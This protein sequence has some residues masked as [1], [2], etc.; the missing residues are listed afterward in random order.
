MP[1]VRQ[2]DSIGR[3]GDPDAWHLAASRLLLAGRQCVGPAWS[4]GQASP[5]VDA[6]GATPLAPPSVSSSRPVRVYSGRSV[7][8]TSVPSAVPSAVSS[9]VSR[10]VAR[11][12]RMRVRS[13]AH[14]SGDDV[15]SAAIEQGR[16]E[17][18]GVAPT[19]LDAGIALAR[20]WRR[21][22]ARRH[23]QSHANAGPCSPAD[24]KKW[25]MGLLERQPDAGLAHMT[26]CLSVRAASCYKGSRGFDVRRDLASSH[27]PRDRG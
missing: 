25:R 24:A 26:S 20:S 4:R 19:I 15:Q 3:A 1:A 8:T 13:R 23:R 27:D 9:H 10:S 22:A 11:R 21:A 17:K 2:D 14:S 7:P 16:P 12:S 5:T 18:E 6:A